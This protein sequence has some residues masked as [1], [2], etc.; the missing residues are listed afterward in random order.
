MFG[1]KV[2]VFGGTG[3]V[4][5]AVVNA[6]SKK[7]YRTQ[8]AVRRPERYRD[9]ALFPNTKVVQC[10][11]FFDLDA[12]G[13][14]LTGTD[15]VINLFA[16]LTSGPEA[17][18]NKEMLDVF[19]NLK[20]VADE[21]HCPRVVSL[22]QLGAD[23]NQD[24]N[25]WLHTLGECDTIMRTLATPKQTILR[26]SLLLGEGDETAT[27]YRNHFNLSPFAMIPHAQTRVQPLA[28][29]DF[30]Q[31]LVAAIADEKTFGK[32]IELAGED[33]LTLKELA[34]L[35]A[36]MAGHEKATVLPMCSLNA[37]FMGLLGPLAPFKTTSSVQFKT[38]ASDMVTEHSFAEQFGFE[39]V[40]LENALASYVS[41]RHIRAR[42]DFFRR[43][44]GR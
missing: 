36:E 42:Y 14:F 8:V 29:G 35:V 39:P 21:V 22:S 20:K 41:P 23:S 19:R 5:R 16:D 9:F 37:R 31:A 15:I 38:L 30:A 44:A 7:G 12:L 32:K 33:R 24:R 17:L 3:L 34:E 43:E 28:V 6:L 25:Q 4:G 10:P 40:S 2:V 13:Q 18:T 27:R 11:D 26:P 1:N